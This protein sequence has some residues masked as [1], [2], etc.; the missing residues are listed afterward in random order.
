MYRYVLTSIVNSPDSPHFVGV[1]EGVLLIVRVISIIEVRVEA[2]WEDRAS[3]FHLLIH[4]TIWPLIV[5]VT[6]AP[7]CL[8]LIDIIAGLEDSGY[9]RPE[10]PCTPVP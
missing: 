5:A 9:G 8:L 6:I 2:G 4:E 3:P 1:D 10:T 7:T